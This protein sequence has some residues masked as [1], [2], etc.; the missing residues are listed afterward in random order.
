MFRSRPVL[1]KGPIEK[2]TVKE[3]KVWLCDSGSTEGLMYP[4]GKWF[5]P[6][7][8]PLTISPSRPITL[9]DSGIVTG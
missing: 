4:M 7:I 1:G 6:G 3:K 9:Q 5:P 8:V 2:H